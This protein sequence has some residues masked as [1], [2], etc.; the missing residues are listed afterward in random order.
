MAPVMDLRQ[1]EKELR[2]GLRR[3]YLRQR[4]ARIDTSQRDPR[5]DLSVVT[6]GGNVRRQGDGEED[7]DDSD[8]EEA[9]KAR[10][11][12]KNKQGKGGDD[13]DDD[14][15]EDHEHKQPV[16]TLALPAPAPTVPSF[17]PLQLVP[18][19][20][21]TS[22]ALPSPTSPASPPTPTFPVFSS[23]PPAVI[24]MPPTTVVKTS[25]VLATPKPS[26]NAPVVNNPQLGPPPPSTT[27]S[28]ISLMT[29]Q[30]LPLVS[31]ITVSSQ[32]RKGVGNPETSSSSSSSP[33]YSESYTQTTPFA[34]EKSSPTPTVSL[35]DVK[36]GNDGGRDQDRGP[37]PGAL[38]PAAEH[39]LISAGSIGGFIIVC[40]ICWMAWRM[41][42]KSKAKENG[43]YGNQPPPSNQLLAKIPYFGRG[44]RG[45]QE[46]DD[47]PNDFRNAPPQYEKTNSMGQISEIYSMYDPRSQAQ[48]MAKQGPMVLPQL[49]TN[50][51]PSGTFNPYS[52]TSGS[53]QNPQSASSPL[54]AQT[55]SPQSQ[56]SQQQ[57]ANFPPQLRPGFSPASNFNPFISN[58]STDASNSMSPN[59]TLQYGA[60]QTTGTM[61]SV[62]STQATGTMQTV[63]TTTTDRSRMQD[64]FFNQSEL[65]RQPS[66]AYDPNRRQVYRASELS[67]LSSGFGDE[68]IIIPPPAAAGQSNAP[69]MPRLSYQQTPIASRKNS[70][71]NASEAGISNRD[72]VYTTTSEDMPPRFRT[73]N[74]WVNQQTGRIRRAEQRAN[75]D[76]PPVP[77]MPAEE[78]YTMMMDDEEPRRP[79]VAQVPVPDLPAAVKDTKP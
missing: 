67:S 36:Y 5:R 4:L 18:P 61:Q 28:S 39:A 79:D 2:A 62:G 22:I 26:A 42:K 10:Q 24:T 57:L 38:S 58:S 17:P 27:T 32:P 51:S 41:V 47:G 64:P 70:V 13:S 63:A 66:D 21:S 34:F 50:F 8:E 30:S 33:T 49:Q 65:A 60:L 53:F 3:R 11:G 16:A 29:T 20:T 55:V 71:A 77:S 23:P 12:T 25:T 6:D 1:E 15:D 54:R 46:M 40:F 19:P 75:E 43:S 52:A 44:Q 48:S 14:H 69:G 37:P 73:V 78:R 45:W 35:E 31:S 74:S 59:S 7:G 56:M 76:I 9:G 68:D 72:T